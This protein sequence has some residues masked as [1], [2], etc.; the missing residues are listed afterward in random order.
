MKDLNAYSLQKKIA[1]IASRKS[2]NIFLFILWLLPLGTLWL[3]LYLLV[4]KRFNRLNP[5][6]NL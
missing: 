3:L 2:E 4:T 5:W 6:R 1:S